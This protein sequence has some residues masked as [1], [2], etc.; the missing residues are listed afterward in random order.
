LS[1][2]NPFKKTKDLEEP[3]ARLEALKKAVRKFNSTERILNKI[4][5]H[6]LR[7]GS[8]RC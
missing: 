2:H 7:L 6:I 1:P 5:G 3:V 8:L 4:N